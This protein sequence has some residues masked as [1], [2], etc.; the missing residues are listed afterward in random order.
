M[1]K[2][3]ALTGSTVKGLNMVLEYT[4]LQLSI[5]FRVECCLDYHNSPSV[6]MPPNFNASAAPA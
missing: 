5:T 4:L 3:N 2:C 6:D 1:E